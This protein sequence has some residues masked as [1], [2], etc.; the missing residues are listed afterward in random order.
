VS[1]DPIFSKF[2]HIRKFTEHSET[3]ALYFPT[4]RLATLESNIV[5]LSYLYEIIISIIVLVIIIIKLLLLLL[6][7][8]ILF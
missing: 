1:F 7:I 8:I 4:T 6:L 5:I 3:L 2:N